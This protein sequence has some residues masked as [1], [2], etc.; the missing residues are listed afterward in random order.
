MGP[1]AGADYT[2]PFLTNNSEVQQLS[3]A[4]MINANECF[5]TYVSQM[6]QLQYRKREST[7]KGEGIYIL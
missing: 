2:S 5:P 4:T 3:L 6:E 7:R 1:F